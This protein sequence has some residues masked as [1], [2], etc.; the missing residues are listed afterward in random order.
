M[1]RAPEHAP[2]GRD[3]VPW[4]LRGPAGSSR[5]KARLLR[6]W[7]CGSPRAAAGPARKWRPCGERGS[8][9]VRKWRERHFQVRTSAAVLLEETTAANP[10]VPGP[11]TGRGGAWLPTLATR[12]ER[13]RCTLA[14]QPDR[15]FW[16]EDTSRSSIRRTINLLVDSDEYGQLEMAS[17]KHS[18][19]KGSLKDLF[20]KTPECGD[21][22]GSVRAESDGAPLTRAFME[23]LFRSSH[24]DFA[25]LK[26]EILADNKDLK[27][28]VI[29]LGQQVDM[30]EQTHDAQEEELDCPR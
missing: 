21:V 7:S 14:L 20:T 5:C 18:K 11:R 24:K 27:R 16:S 28:E 15:D 23:Q 22:A 12:Q 26:R 6:A 25:T 17:K 19:K 3:G 1:D 10:G 2:G 9:A 8:L 4:M 29:D 13:R 30:V